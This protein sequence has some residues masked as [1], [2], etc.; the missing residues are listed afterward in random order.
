MNEE[1]KPKPKRRQLPAEPLPVKKIKLL[2]T[3]VNKN[4]AEFYTDLLQSFEINMQMVMRAYGTAGSEMLHYMELEESE[5]TV[6]FS[7]VATRSSVTALL[8]L[9]VL[10]TSTS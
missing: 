8:P 6:I 3:V 7:F 9:L 5:K 1:I 2:V 10:T 4:K